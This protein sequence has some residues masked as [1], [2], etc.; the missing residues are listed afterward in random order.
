MGLFKRDRPTPEQ[1][2]GMHEAFW[3]GPFKPPRI[4]DTP[5]ARR[6]YECHSITRQVVDGA[7][8]LME[9]Q[10]IT[11]AELAEELGTNEFTVQHLLSGNEL[12]QLPAIA[13]LAAGLK[14]HV[15]VRLVPA[16]GGKWEDSAENN[17][18]PTAL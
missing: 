2:E 15:E 8:A 11:P 18:P 17:N 1:V 10:A 7:S 5:E 6:V 16:I 12:L 9:D 4:P 3:N 14:A 13:R